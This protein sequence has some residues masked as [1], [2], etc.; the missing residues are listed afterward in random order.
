MEQQVKNPTAAAWVAI[1]AQDQYSAWYSGLKDQALLQLQHRSKLW[2]GFSPC[3]G[4]FHMPWVW[5]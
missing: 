2:F 5:P 3:P 1:E 4:K